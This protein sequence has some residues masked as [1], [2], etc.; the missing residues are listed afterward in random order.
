M[1]QKFWILSIVLFLGIAIYLTARPTSPRPVEYGK[2]SI[3][4]EKCFRK[5]QIP[6]KKLNGVLLVDRIKEID[7]ISSCT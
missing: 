2:W 5:Y 7:I 6:Y 1:V 3:S 4:Y